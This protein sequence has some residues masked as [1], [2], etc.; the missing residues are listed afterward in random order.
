MTTIT[1][2]D[3]GDPM[4]NLQILIDYLNDECSRLIPTLHHH[5]ILKND[6]NTISLL[7]S[8]SGLTQKKAVICNINKNYKEL[9]DE[10]GSYA[11]GMIYGLMIYGVMCGDIK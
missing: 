3:E 2:N 11:C 10:I 1:W 6:G 7:L 8:K 5:Y 9:W 4:L